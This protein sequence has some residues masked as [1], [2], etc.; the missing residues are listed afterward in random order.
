MSKAKALLDSG[1][2]TQAEYE[3]LKASALT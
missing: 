1:T 2:I 3:R